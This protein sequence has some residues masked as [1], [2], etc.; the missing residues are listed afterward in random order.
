MNTNNNL[1]STLKALRLS[2]LAQS[3]PVRLQEVAAT[4]LSHGEFLELIRFLHDFGGIG[5]EEE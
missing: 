4:R 1:D 2:G 5:P 3:L